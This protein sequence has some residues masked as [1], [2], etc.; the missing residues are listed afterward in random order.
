MA[1]RA[2]SSQVAIEEGSRVLGKPGE[3]FAFVDERVAR[4]NRLI[5]RQLP[6]VEFRDDLCFE[7]GI[8]GGAA[9][10]VGNQSIQV[11]TNLGGVVVEPHGKEVKDRIV[12]LLHR[13]RVRFERVRP[14]HRREGPQMEI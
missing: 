13:R 1:S 8:E 2:Q 10:V 11:G 6:A 4:A 14:W 12:E 7:V 9:L 5:L 3:V